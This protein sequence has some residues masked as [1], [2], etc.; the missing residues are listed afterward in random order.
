[1]PGVALT[2]LHRDTRV[3]ALDKPSGLVV[4]RSEQVSDRDNC[5]TR[6]RR[7]LGQW[8]W[9]V[10]RLDRGASGALL[11]A[12][13]PEAAHGLALAFAQ[14]RVDKLY[15]AVVR[16]YAPSTGVIDY[17]L[18]DDEGGA[19]AEA[20]TRFACLAQVE[21]PIA[22]GRYGSA[23]YSLVSAE[24]RSGRHHQIRRHLRHIGHPLIGDVTHGE[25]RHNRLFREHFGCR[26]L[27]LHAWH[28]R[29]PHPAQAADVD[30]CAPLPV[31]FAQVCARLGWSDALARAQPR[32]LATPLVP[33]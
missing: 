1:M 21:L 32:Q 29:A 15:L 5:M 31:D 22:V 26:R 3:V 7:Q 2:L 16:G 18:T 23:R 17:A 4:H 24:P 28:L 30:V 25:G 6:L 10:H 20:I 11:F 13:D 8:V 33:S 27:L 19:P 12:L 14:R 9:P